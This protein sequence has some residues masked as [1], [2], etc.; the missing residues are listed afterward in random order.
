MPNNTNRIKYLIW[1]VTSYSQKPCAYAVSE[2][3]QPNFTISRRRK[4]ETFHCQFCFLRFGWRHKLLITLMPLSEFA[5]ISK[6]YVFSS[7]TLVKLRG[8]TLQNSLKRTFHRAS[9]RPVRYKI[10]TRQNQKRF[11]TSA[12]R[13]CAAP[14]GREAAGAETALP[15]GGGR[16]H[17]SGQIAGLILFLL[18]CTF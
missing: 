14:G 12:G 18:W 13:D 3:R 7:C 10:T 5:Q 8:A 15:P 11:C 6:A 2:S 16:P 4:C 17:R 9:W 1:F